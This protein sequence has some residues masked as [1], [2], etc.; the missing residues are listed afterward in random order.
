MEKLSRRAFF[1]LTGAAALG[2]LIAACAPAKPAE[3]PQATQA[4]AGVTQ[5]PAQGT[6][7]TF[8]PEWGGKDSDALL[9]QV[10][11]FTEETGIPV[12]Y[13][14]IRDHAR[15][16]ASMGA[17]NPP[18]L[19]MTW[20]AGA[21]GTWFFNGAIKE[22]KPYVDK[23][24]F[25]LTKLHPMG[26]AAGTMLGHLIALSLSNYL[27]S[28]L[29]WNK[30]IFKEEGLDPETP[31][32]TWEE[33]AAWSDKLTK[34]EGDEIKRLGFLVNYGQ[35]SAGTIQY[36]WGGRYYSEDGTQVTCDND[37]MIAALEYTR[38]FFQKY[39]VDKV[40]RFSSG[41]S[42]DVDNPACPFY[43]GAG[44]IRLDGE[45]VPTFVD[46]VK[47]DLDYGVGYMPYPESMSASKGVMV[48][49]AN[50]LVI[51]SAAKNPDGGWSLVQF[52]NK[53]EVS[54]EMLAIVGNASPVKEGIN[55]LI[56]KTKNEKYKWLLQDPWTKATIYP[57]TVMSPVGAL[58]S[59]ELSRAVEAVNNLQQEP[60]AAMKAVKDKV[61]PELDAALKKMGAK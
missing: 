59:D 9:A 20:D 24:G 18:D 56:E 16:I 17:G 52:L 54:A 34:I 5:A 32:S 10:Q 14:P 50:P 3:A 38:S 42:A 41:L 8:W 6:M 25:D 15:M 30:A 13:L 37:G 46:Q 39:G 48:A 36:S 60:A 22:I 23:S 2:A 43:T 31:P 58:Y 4:A 53:P 51:P 27:N 28:A 45:W 7:V 12:Q 21:V 33:M 49:N 44:V 11:K 29:Y 61:Q 35:Y 19:L 57:L 40:Q 26:V 47:P 1:R 55:L